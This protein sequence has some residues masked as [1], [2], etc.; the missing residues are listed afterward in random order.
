MKSRMM[1]SML[2]IALVAAVI[3]GG[4]M[5]WFTA[6]AEVENTFTAGTVM[7]TAG[8]EV[9]SEGLDE[10]NVNPGD[11][12]NKEFTI[13]NTGSKNIYLKMCLL[14]EWVFDWEWLWDNWDALCFSGNENVTKPEDPY[15][16]EWT[17]I[18]S[19]WVT[20]MEYVEGLESPVDVDALL[21]D[22]EGWVE[23]NGCYIYVPD[24]EVLAP[25]GGTLVFDF[26]ICF[27]GPKMDNFF[28]GVAL[29][30]TFSFEAVQ[31][32]NDAPYH[33]WGFEYPPS[34]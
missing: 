15:D 28:Q 13:V 2:V 6:K 11:C 23:H 5:A 8:D 31:S 10:E 27:N 18:P 4:T 17:D 14:E 1:I 29:N 21:A 20:F 3:G 19:D 9:T 16:E 22:L 12:F 24:G 26:D 25:D 7:I 34:E 30:L 32:S 33:A